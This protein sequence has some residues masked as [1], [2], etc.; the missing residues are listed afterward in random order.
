MKSDNINKLILDICNTKDYFKIT[1]TKK[2]DLLLNKVEKIEQFL[3]KDEQE[4]IKIKYVNTGNKTKL[5]AAISRCKIRGYIAREST[6]EIKYWKN[7]DKTIIE[8]VLERQKDDI[9]EDDWE[10][11]DPENE[12]TSIIG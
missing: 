7:S 9:Y 4:N 11:F 6:P 12:E 5:A 10:C 1:I 2:I 3:L 8:R